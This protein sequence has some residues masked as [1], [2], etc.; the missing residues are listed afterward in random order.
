MPKWAQALFLA[1]NFQGTTPD[2][3]IEMDE[4]DY[5]RFTRFWGGVQQAKEQRMKSR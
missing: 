2:Y 1:E 4:L 3:W 5:S